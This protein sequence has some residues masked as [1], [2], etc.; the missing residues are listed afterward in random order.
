MLRP[1]HLASFLIFSLHPSDALC[2]LN[3]SFLRRPSLVSSFCLFMR[4]YLCPKRA[5]LV[6]IR[7]A[8]VANAYAKNL[9]QEQSFLIFPPQD[10]RIV[11]PFTYN[12]ILGY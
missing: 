3:L 8:V 6:Q 10:T 7:S 2:F 1:F 9:F 4:I 12:T 11:I 5:S